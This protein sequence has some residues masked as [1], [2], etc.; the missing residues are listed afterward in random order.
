M[1]DL[2]TYGGE[3]IQLL[4]L[5]M[6]R[7]GGMMIAAP[8]FS[9]RSIP[10]RLMIAMALGLTV[11]IMIVY[12]DTP[13]PQISNVYELGLL[14]LRE[15]FVGL[16]IGLVFAVVFYGVRLAGSI[17]GYQIGFAMVNVVDPNSSAQVSILGEVWFLL[18][19]LIFLAINGHHMIIEGTALSFTVLPLGQVDAGGAVGTWFLKYTSFAFVLAIRLAS[20]VMITIFLIEVTM[21]ILARTMPQMNIFI[22]G[23]PIKIF[24]GLLMIGISL[25]VFSYVLQKVS[26]G[27]DR[28]LMHL[29][30]I[31]QK[32]GVS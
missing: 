11:T 13:L 32:S 16:M 1:Y 15:S 10:R 14:C 28:E 20:P 23:F 8:I 12:I 7:V 22:V 24:V 27:L 18:G 3:K 29:M 2:V 4:L 21:G 30:T 6:T 25:P 5:I 9:H 31:Y 19:T 17:V 26:N